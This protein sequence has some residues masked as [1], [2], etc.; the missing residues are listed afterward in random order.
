MSKTAS[1]FSQLQLNIISDCKLKQKDNRQLA[2]DHNVNYAFIINTYSKYRRLNGL[3]KTRDSEQ[4]VTDTE[5]N[6]DYK[7]MVDNMKAAC[8]QCLGAQDTVE[9]AHLIADILKLI[10]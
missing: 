3:V 5:V 6:I 10:S 8:I 7:T 9:T 2:A 4:T 1:P